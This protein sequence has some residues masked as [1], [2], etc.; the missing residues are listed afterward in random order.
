ML[1]PSPIDPLI[2]EESFADWAVLDQRES[3]A[4]T[5]EIASPH[6]ADQAAGAMVEAQGLARREDGKVVLTAAP[7]G[8]SMQ[9]AVICQA[10]ENQ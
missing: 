8:S 9:P 4:T 6:Q 1:P 3:R 10:S 7:A 2:G 5:S